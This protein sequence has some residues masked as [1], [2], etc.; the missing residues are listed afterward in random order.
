M[1]NKFKIII[2]YLAWAKTCWPAK[3]NWVSSAVNWANKPVPTFWISA[4]MFPKPRVFKKKSAK[5]LLPLLFNKAAN[6]AT[7]A[8]KIVEEFPKWF[9][10][11]VANCCKIGLVKL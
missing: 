8:D 5:S 3:T 6:W 2:S 11:S 4:Q 9:C 7:A 1:S 10:K